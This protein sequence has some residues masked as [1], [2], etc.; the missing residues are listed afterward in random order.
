MGNEA[1][2]PSSGQTASPKESLEGRDNLMLL[3]YF[4]E[5]TRHPFNA[6]KVMDLVLQ[7]AVQGKLT[8]K[9][10]E[11]NPEV[12]PASVLLEKIKEEKEKL[13][14]EKKV[15]KEKQLASVSEEEIPYVVPYSWE[16]VRL[17]MIG[18]IFNGNSISASIKASKYEGLKDGYPFIATKD[19]GYGFEQIDEE[20]GVRIPFQE[21]KFKIARK[22]TVLICS[23][24]GSSGKKM[25]LCT[26]DICFGNKLYAIE[27]Y[28]DIESKYILGFYYTSIFYNLFSEKMTGLIGGISMSKFKDIPFPL[29]PLKEQKEIVQIVDQLKVE[30]D[31]LN[32]LSNERLEKKHQFVVSSMHHLTESGDAE[33]WN[34]LQ[35]H[36]TDTIDELDN[37]K[38]L[39]E[40]ILQLA[41]QGKLT[42]KWRN[43]H[44]EALEGC[45]SASALLKHIQEEKEKLIAEKKIKKEKPLLPI[46]QEE[47]PYAL[48]GGWEWFRVSQ[49]T[50]PGALITY[51]ILKPVWVED[52]VPTV[53]IKDMKNGEIDASEIAMCQE[54]RALKF[55]KTE[56]KEGD[57]LIAKD[58]G[59]LGKT[60]FVPKA[61][62]GGNITQHVL[63]FSVH[64]EINKR[65]VRFNI[66][67]P[68]GQQFMTGE[69][70]G[71]ALPGVN[72]GDFRNMLIGIPPAVE[73]NAIVQQVDHLMS[74]C[75][76]LESHIHTRN[77]TAEKLMKAVVEEVLEKNEND[78]LPQSN[79]LK[80][81]NGLSEN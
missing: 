77:E 78:L 64:Y 34:L 32:R 6:E 45:K 44:P 5:L 59:T 29:P 41:V 65:F 24:G 79:Y 23:E 66:D 40:T 62:E 47:I 63:R 73:Q 57:I 16:W 15:R 51:G 19:V 74:L 71:V 27:Q 60:A 28:G 17:G 30:I 2:I 75:D 8:K 69:T 14:A 12:E 10:R 26:Q 68:L 21:S 53:R 25:G 33:H 4:P 38:K 39:R 9:W 31:K 76:T 55:L 72:V 42:Q 81:S 58:G 35:D 49:L 46:S 3:E 54:D 50:R 36:F 22:N 1:A 48:P 70:K 7:L 52:G 80:A 56:L 13:V 37:V 18:N 67:S 11:D 61:L 43:E 20:N